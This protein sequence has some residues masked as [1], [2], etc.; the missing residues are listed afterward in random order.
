[1]IT[2]EYKY[3]KTIIMVDFMLIKT[4]QILYF[5]CF[6]SVFKIVGKRWVKLPRKL[7]KI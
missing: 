4:H 2:K 5:N 3:F 7:F 6:V 1:M